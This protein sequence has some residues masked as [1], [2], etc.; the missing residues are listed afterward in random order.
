MKTLAICLLLLTL[1]CGQGPSPTEESSAEKAAAPPVDK[2]IVVQFMIDGI[3]GNT[4]RTAVNSGA[5]TLG[6]VLEQGVTVERFFCTSPAPRLELPD[7]SLPWGGSTSANIALHTGCHL[8]ESRRMDDI[9][10]SARRAGI[11]SVFAGG[12]PN[13]SVFDTADHL[14]FGDLSDEEVVQRGLDHFTNDGARLLR[15]HLQRIRDHWSGPTDTTDAN[16]KYVQYFVNSVDP[17]LAKLIDGLK[18]AGV[19]ERTYLIIGSD[20]GMGQT[21][22]SNHP[23]SVRSSWE[24]FMAFYGPGVKRGATIPYAEGPDVALMTN[25]FFGLPPL[26]GHLEGD[27]PA[28]LRGPTGTMLENILEGGPNDI[29][30]P[31]WIERLLDAG[32][33]GDAYVEYRERMLKL[34]SQ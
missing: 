29:A 17:L 31:R 8:F 19:W 25:H 28:G 33:P 10:L 34:L 3:D 4:V 27:L 21:G 20:H 2:P 23:Q 32:M 13:Y 14:Y 9:F 6:G 18:S 12:S 15:L 1:A 22:A 30:H 5:K 24:T 11:V 16:S 7:G 26:A